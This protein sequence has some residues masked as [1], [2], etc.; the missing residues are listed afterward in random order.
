MIPKFFFQN[1]PS[2]KLYCLKLYKVLYWE[3]L[4][5]VNALFSGK[6]ADTEGECTNDG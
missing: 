5:S 1:I 2:G 6:V 4:T 3:H